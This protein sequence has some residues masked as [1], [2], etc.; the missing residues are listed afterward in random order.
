M[1][2]GGYRIQRSYGKRKGRGESRPGMVSD[3][4]FTSRV[5]I[6]LTQFMLIYWQLNLNIGVLIYWFR[7]WCVNMLVQWLYIDGIDGRWCN[8]VE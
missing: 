1:V 7:G 4:N 8:C 3:D 6:N 5:Y 2:G